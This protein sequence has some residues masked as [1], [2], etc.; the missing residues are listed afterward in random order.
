MLSLLMVFSMWAT[1]VWAMVEATVDAELI[2]QGYP[3]NHAIKVPIRVILFFVLGWFQWEIVLVMAAVFWLSFDMMLN[4]L[5]G[6][7]PLYVGQTA[8][9]DKAQHRIA[10]RLNVPVGT[11]SVVLK[12][13]MII[14]TLLI[15]VL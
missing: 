7:P 6:L 1:L 4:H 3:I 9:I 5:R 10:Q 15:A 8:A 14:I 2:R 12:L 11:L 13:C